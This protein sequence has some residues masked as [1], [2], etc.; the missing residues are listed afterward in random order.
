MLPLVLLSGEATR[1]GDKGRV[2]GCGT[3]DHRTTGIGQTEQP[4]N[5]VVGLTR[6]VVYGRAKLGDR[7]G[8]V[9][10]QEQRGVAAGNQERDAG[11]GQRS[12]L[13]NVDR[14]VASKV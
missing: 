5:L 6:R 7:A 8:H 13:E 14:Y 1:K 9:L 3:I 10:D 12:V 2:A 4:G 11:L